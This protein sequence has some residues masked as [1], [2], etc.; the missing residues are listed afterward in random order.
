MDP[1]FS[2]LMLLGQ[3]TAGVD[4]VNNMKRSITY[5]I[6]LKKISIHVSEPS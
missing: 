6:Q 3:K 1:V 2:A 5:R 4:A